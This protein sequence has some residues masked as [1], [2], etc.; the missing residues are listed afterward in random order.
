ML[1]FES[2]PAQ[3]VR[4]VFSYADSLMHNSRIGRAGKQHFI[5]VAVKPSVW[6]PQE[7]DA[8][9]APRYASDE[10]GFVYY[11]INRDLT[12]D[13]LELLAQ[14]SMVPSDTLSFLRG[15]ALFDD[16]QLEAADRW[17]SASS[18]EPALFYE[19]VAKAHLGNPAQAQRRLETYSG[20]RSELACL[21]M[22]GLDLLQGNVGKYRAHAAS[23]TYSDFNLTESERALDNV[24]NSVASHRDKSPLA[25]AL[26]SAFLPGSGQLYAGNTGEALSAFLTVGSLAGLT[27][28]N[29]H[30]YGVK[31]W[32]TIVPG[33]IGSVFYIGNIYGA[34]I[35]VNIYNQEFKDETS[36]VVLYNI[37]IP[38]RSIYH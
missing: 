31:S 30:K 21:Q 2:L 4:G 27:A 35:S 26:F 15:L 33:A 10:C 38:L 12:R 32:R 8:S 7:R 18:L 37:H 36:A 9:L 11:L 29:W 1:A 16:L 6:V 34:Y 19:V 24:A 25:A 22:A 23:F 28:V 14:P 13:A 20:P 5:P 17:L 3:H